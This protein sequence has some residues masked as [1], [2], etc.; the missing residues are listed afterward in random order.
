V[1][2]C[3]WWVCRPRVG[4]H[5]FSVLSPPP[6]VVIGPTSTQPTKRAGVQSR[7]FVKG[8]SS[9]IATYILQR[10]GVSAILYRVLAGTLQTQKPADR[11][12]AG[13]LGSHSRTRPRPEPNYVLPRQTDIL[14]PHS[15]IPIPSN[16]T[17]LLPRTTRVFRSYLDLAR[18]HP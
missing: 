2:V 5:T 1:L 17:Y 12:A 14:K 18:G 3:T 9:G 15:A 4:G 8:R 7:S 16:G 10:C 13:G 11:P 6:P